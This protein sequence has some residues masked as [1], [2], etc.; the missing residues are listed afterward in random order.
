M[1]YA[2]SIEAVNPLFVD[3]VVGKRLEGQEFIQKTSSTAS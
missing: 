1:V 3:C 2:I